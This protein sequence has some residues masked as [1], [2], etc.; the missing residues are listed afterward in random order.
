MAE[1]ETKLLESLKD[2]VAL[3]DY[4]GQEDEETWQPGQPWIFREDKLSAKKRLES[5]REAIAKAEG[6]P[7]E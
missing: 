3:L 7:L 4:A 1:R 5:L 6:R 2:A